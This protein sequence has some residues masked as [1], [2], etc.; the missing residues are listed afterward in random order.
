MSCLRRANGLRHA[1][2]WTRGVKWLSAKKMFFECVQP[3]PDVLFRQTDSKSSFSGGTA[4]PMDSNCVPTTRQVW[5]DE[6]FTC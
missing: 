6:E 5:F 3:V 1:D 2:S 4:G